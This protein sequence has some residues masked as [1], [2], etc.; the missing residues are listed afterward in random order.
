[1]STM[2]PEAPASLRERKKLETK[3]ALRSA[4]VRLYLEHGPDAVTVHGICESAGVSPRTFFNYFETKDDAVFDWDHRLTHQLAI[5]VR[6]RPADESPLDALHRTVHEAIPALVA[7]PGWRDRGKLLRQHPELVPKLLHSNRRMEEAIACEV[8]ARTGAPAE[9]RYPRLLAA[10]GLAALRTAMRD[11][12]PD[13]G[14]E[15][16]LAL[17]DEMYGMLAGGLR[18]PGAD[19]S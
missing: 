11:W 12:D 6:E 15:G 18:P 3:N 13:S 16:L 7:D 8:A 17:T 4:A 19:D 10:A 2:D 14:A 1:M 5:G 9:A